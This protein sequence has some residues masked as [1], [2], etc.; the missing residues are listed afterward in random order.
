MTGVKRTD[1]PPGELITAVTVPLLDG[2]Q[3][4]AKVGVRNAMVIAI[5]GACLAVDRPVALGAPRPRFGR[6]DD[7][8]GA[9][10]RGVR[11]GAVDWGAGTV[12]EAAVVRVRAPGGRGQ[13]ADRRPPLD[14]GLPAPRGRG[15]R[16]RSCGAAMARRGVT[17]SEQYRLHVNGADHD[18]ADAWLG[19]SLLYVLRERLGLLGAKGAC[20][21]GECGSCSVLVD[22]ELVCS[23]LVLAAS[24]VDVP[25]VTVEGLADA[26]RRP[27]CSGRSSTPAPCS[28]GS[29]RRGW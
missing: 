22:G 27:T 1:R 4:Y 3:G 14:R 13:P 21:Q 25:I 2:W 26:G 28:A 18:V 19:E 5:A 29:A 7:R 20:E 15:A 24:A 17:M 16:R 11:R 8:A 23:C 10:G 6:P 12:G 9:G